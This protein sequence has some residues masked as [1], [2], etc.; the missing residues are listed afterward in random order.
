VTRLAF[1]P[2][3]YGG[4]KEVHTSVSHNEGWGCG[5]IKEQEAIKMKEEYVW[6]EDRRIMIPLVLAV[7]SPGIVKILLAIIGL[8]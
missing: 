7:L 6:N 3:Q 4:V 5:K 8:F 1:R 2:G